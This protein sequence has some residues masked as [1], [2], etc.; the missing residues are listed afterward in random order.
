MSVFGRT[1]WCGLSV[2]CFCSGIGQRAFSAEGPLS[3][4]QIIGKA[5][6]RTQRPEPSAAPP[7]YAYTKVTLTEEFGPDGK[8]REHKE[9]VYEVCLRNGAT[10][11]KLVSVNGH[12][13]GAADRKKQAENESNSRKVMG[14]GNGSQDDSH[15]KLLTPE[16][17]ARFDFTLVDQQSINGRPAF[18]LRFVPKNPAPPVHR[19]ADRLADRISG[20]LWVDAQEF[21]VARAELRLGS[22]VN[23]LGGVLGSLK[24]LA[25]TMTRTR[26]ADG[27]WLNTSSAGDFEGRKLLDFLRIKTKSQSSNF[28]PLALG[29]LTPHVRG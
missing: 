6:A 10:E 15:E 12:A 14:Q 18:R 20:T 8:V 17:V 4:E 21:E 1:A 13:P 2:L 3:A 5:V 22:E 9:K 24:R 7:A 27:L 28:H 11:V 19:M 16:L 26:I 29:T 23:L 25:Y